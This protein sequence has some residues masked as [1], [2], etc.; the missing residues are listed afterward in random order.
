VLLLTFEDGDTELRRRLRAARL[1]Y[2]IN[3]ADIKGYLF[4][5]AISSSDVKLAISIDGRRA[6]GNLVATLSALIVKRQ[7]DTLIVEPF[8]KTHSISENDNDAMDF[9]AGLLTDLAITHNIAAASAHHTRKGI[10]EPGNA[11]SGR[12]ASSLKDAARL[13]YTLSGM[14]PED[15]RNFSNVD[16]SERRQHVRLDSGKV[17]LCPAIDAQWYKIVG[18]ELGN[19]TKLYP[20]GDNVQAIECWEPALPTM[21]QGDM[22]AILTEIEQGMPDG[23]LY[24]YHHLATAR[25]VWQV[26]MKHR[27]DLNKEQARKIV[28][29]WLERGIVYEDEFEEP[30]NRK[31]RKG[32]R[33]RGQKE[34]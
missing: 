7:I 19:A 16:A 31:K 1:R 24:M 33:V 8:V 27:Q 14:T 4:C 21:D 5:K 20:N 12:G 32:L 11:D 2:G 10:V 13:V 18:V 29:G 6:A 34:R 3:G 23:G 17:N 28:K 9:V 25:G 22:A 15:A 30:G 26:L